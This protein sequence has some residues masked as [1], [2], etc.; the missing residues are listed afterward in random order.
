LACFSHGVA[1]GLSG[2]G[3]LAFEKKPTRARPSSRA[4]FSP[5][6]KI[7]RPCEKQAKPGPAGYQNSLHQFNK[8]S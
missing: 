8:P 7:E 4:Q 1:R 3:L 2:H 6:G 5:L